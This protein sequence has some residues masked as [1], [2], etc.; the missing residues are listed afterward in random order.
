M[1]EEEDDEEE[2]R[3][4]VDRVLK[5]Y[6]KF[7]VQPE[8]GEGDFDKRHDLMIQEKMDEWKRAY[9]RVSLTISLIT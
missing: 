3:V 4:A 2:G 5:K 8:D 1:D 6:E 7:K 9:Y